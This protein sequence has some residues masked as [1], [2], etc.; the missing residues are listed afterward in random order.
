[1]CCE[2]RHGPGRRPSPIDE[3][4][5]QVVHIL[6][7]VVSLSESIRSFSLTNCRVSSKAPGGVGVDN[8]GA[9]APCEQIAIAS[10]SLSRNGARAGTRRVDEIETEAPTDERDVLDVSKRLWAWHRRQSQ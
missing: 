4:R 8:A 5:Q 7:D 2:A 10:Q 6:A 3:C 1:L 9:L